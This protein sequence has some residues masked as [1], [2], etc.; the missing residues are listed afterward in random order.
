ME[1]DV[2]RLLVCY[3]P[4][5][6]R[7]RVTAERTPFVH[8][9]LG[10]GRSVELS[11]LLGADHLPT[12]LTGVPPHEH[13][14]WEVSLRPESRIPGKPRP[15]AR[16]G[17]ALG[18]FL[19]CARH[20]VDRRDPLP[21]LPPRRRRQFVVR[22]PDYHRGGRGA[23][24]LETLA[25]Q[26]TVFALVPDSRYLFTRRLAALE[27]QAATLPGGDCAL[28]FLEVH[29]L[30]SVQRWHLDVP[31]RVERAYRWL[32]RLLR[33]L[34]ERCKERGVTLLLLSDHGQ[35]P[36]FGAVPLPAALR[37]AGVAETEYTFYVE[38][39]MARFW[40]HTEEARTRLT[41][42][43][44]GIENTRL[45]TLQDLRAA[46]LPF[47]DDAYGELFLVAEPGWILFPNDRRHPL[48]D[49]TRGLL[50][51]DQHP[52]LFDPRPRGAHGYLPESPS[53]RGFL[54]AT[55]LRLRPRRPGGR[56]I[57][58]APTLLAMLGQAPPVY[59]RG[60]ALFG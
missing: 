43:L 10:D 57:D 60:D 9:R 17:D 5:F 34:D 26:P 32:D 27:R 40:F 53:E 12:L 54:L 23:R 30:E 18:T 37:A 33:G 42:V 36:V 31:A 38:P 44:G 19:Q 11:T 50:D 8:A 24:G 28:E 4:G 6:D 35:E 15:G 56:L 21:A 39:A 29:A 3:L 51:P 14:M 52:R 46:D 45:L 55:D 2:S 58:V 41:Q 49:V 7:R 22:R 59:M 20:L 1:P 13:R 16:L 25:G 47:E 48:L